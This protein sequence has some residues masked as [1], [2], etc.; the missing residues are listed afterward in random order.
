MRKVALSIKGKREIA[1]VPTMGALHN[2]H[3]SLVKKAKTIA[4][5]VVVSIFINPIQFSEKNDLKNYPKNLQKDLI[6]LK[7]I[8]VDYV[9]IPKAEEI[10]G[11]DFQTKVIVKDLQQHL[12]GLKRK[13]HFDGVTTIVL[14]LFNIV[15]PDKALFG[16]KDMQQLL[17]IKKM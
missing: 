4:D 7:E 2:G 9:F 15:K 3:L 14:K 5:I 13:N 11:L 6:E 17:I 1:F 10:F 16:K 8:G 12:C